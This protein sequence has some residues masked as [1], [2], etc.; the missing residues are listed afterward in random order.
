LIFP[1]LR[2][3]IAADPVIPHAHYLVFLCFARKTAPPAFP[4]V[5]DPKNPKSAVAETTALYNSI[6]KG[7]DLPD[8]TL[9]SLL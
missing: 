5:Q 4:E 2:V 6:L 1:V 8:L 9:Q 7:I 3:G